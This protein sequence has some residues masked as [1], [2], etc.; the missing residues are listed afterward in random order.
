MNK[1]RFECAKYI[2]T[3]LE[4]KYSGVWLAVLKARGYGSS[5]ISYFDKCYILFEMGEYEV[6]IAK[7]SR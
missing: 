3:Q 2:K 5:L 6:E 1:S 7:T 4:S